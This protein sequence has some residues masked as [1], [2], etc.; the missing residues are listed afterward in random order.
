MSLCSASPPPPHPILPPQP[1]Q[2]RPLQGN[3][4][5]HSPIGKCAN[6][7]VLNPLCLFFFFF[8]KAGNPFFSDSTTQDI[9]FIPFLWATC[10]TPA[11]CTLCPS[12]TLPF[13]GVG[14]HLCAQL[15]PLRP[16]HGLCAAAAQGEQEGRGCRQPRQA[17]LLHAVLLCLSPPTRCSAPRDLCPPVPYAPRAFLLWDGLLFPPSARADALSLC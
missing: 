13:A 5:L 8:L 17:Q 16:G 15:L 3:E 10:R 6:W 9:F 2:P 12:N 1:S 4:T 14:L 7:N 11:I